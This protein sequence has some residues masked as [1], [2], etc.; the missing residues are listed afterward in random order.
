MSKIDAN[1]INLGNSFVLN[2]SGSVVVNKEISDAQI[3]ADSIVAEAKKK[4]TLIISN[5]QNE[6]AEMVNQAISDAE[7]CRDNVLS[8]AQT[9]GFEQGYA[10]G[11]EQIQ[12]DLTELICNVDKFSQC[13]F[14]I[15]HRIIK[16]LHNDILSLVIEIS[17]KICKT[18][19]TED[20]AIL[21]NVVENA[22]SQLKDKE[23]VTI[24]V[25]P[26]MAEKIYAI[27]DELKEKIHNLENIKIIEDSSV[28][29]DGTIVEAVGS[30]IDSR[31]SAQIEQ[32]S[33]KLFAELNATPE[34]ELER[35]LND[36]DGMNDNDDKSGQI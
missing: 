13:K 15:K 25:N 23:N 36:I 21:L 31:V 11:K 18:K 2:T 17:E 9:Q 30:R 28:S 29:P 32:F 22:I 12:K 20:K 35:E 16:S 33:Q 19:I 10:E 26:L 14:D 6:A 24:I 34:I 5:A 3:I 7:N 1:K 8:E 4:A 27:S